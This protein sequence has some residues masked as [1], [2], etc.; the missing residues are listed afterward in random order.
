MTKSAVSRFSWRIGGLHGLLFTFVGGLVGCAGNAGNVEPLPA[1][2]PVIWQQEPEDGF[3]AVQADQFCATA[4]RVEAISAHTLHVDD[5]GMRGVVAGNQSRRVELAFTYRGPSHDE[6][7]LASGELRRQLG[8]KLRAKDT[9]NVVYVM[10]H[11]APT[12]GIYVSVKHNPGQVTHSDCADGGYLNVKPQSTVP[13]PLIT[14]DVPHTM[15][16]ELDGRLLRVFAD[17]TLAWTGE[18]PDVMLTFDGPVGTRSD[19]GV[20]DFELRVPTAEVRQVKCD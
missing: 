11:V 1:A 17:G 9:C 8:L 20:Y 4:G 2:T 3:S 16:A 6:A 7:P 12:P 14:A 18:L 10:W 13:V 5:G 19:N 15:R